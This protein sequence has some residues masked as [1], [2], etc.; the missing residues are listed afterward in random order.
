[1][2]TCNCCLLHVTSTTHHELAA[3][4]AQQE[5]HHP[6]TPQRL[7]F[8]DRWGSQLSSRIQ[9]ALQNSRVERMPKLC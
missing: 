6:D 8:R 5:R 2:H 4:R 1:M 3:R 9:T 7:G